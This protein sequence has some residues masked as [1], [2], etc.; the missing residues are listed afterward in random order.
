MAGMPPSKEACFSLSA[1]WLW[2]SRY[3]ESKSQLLRGEERWHA[4]RQ[5]GAGLNTSTPAYAH[6]FYFVFVRAGWW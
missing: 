6:A 1:W 5:A 4:Y 2:G 3:K